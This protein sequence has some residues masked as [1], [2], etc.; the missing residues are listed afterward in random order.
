M[1]RFEAAAQSRP[2]RD[3]RAGLCGGNAR[4]TTSR[5]GDRCYKIHRLN[6]GDVTFLL[7]SGG[8]NGGIVSEPGHTH[9]SYRIAR[10]P[11]GGPAPEPAA[12]M[13]K[14]ARHE[15]SW[16]PAY[17]D[18]LDA[19]SGPPGPPPATGAALAAAPGSYVLEH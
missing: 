18:W 15:G 9:R 3:F 4:K 1:G 2:W 11:P 5:P 14:S 10:R 19:H 13:E 12:F 7:A 17:A 16:W 6:P 8:H